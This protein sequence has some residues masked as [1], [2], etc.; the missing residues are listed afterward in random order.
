M[1]FYVAIALLIATLGAAQAAPGP[2]PAVTLPTNVNLKQVMGLWWRPFKSQFSPTEP[3]WK[4][5]S[6]RWLNLQ[7]DS[8]FNLIDYNYEAEK[9]TES[10]WRGD[11]ETT[12]GGANWTM[13]F[14]CKHLAEWSS[15][16]VNFLIQIFFL[17]IN[18]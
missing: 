7:S 5:L 16:S 1:K 11:I 15:W 9:G 13:T 4:C 12:H 3:K 10:V 18:R 14:D 17:Q 8:S 2:C 6:T